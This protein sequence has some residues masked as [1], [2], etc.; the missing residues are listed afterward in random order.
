MTNT[1][2]L[3]AVKPNVRQAANDAGNMFGIA[4][5]LGVGARDGVSD[6]PKG[7]ALD[8]MVPGNL[9]KGNQVAQYFETNAAKYGVHY[10]IWKQHIINITERPNEGWRAMGDRGSITANHFD[11]VHVSFNNVAVGTQNAIKIPGIPGIPNPLGG[12][13]NGAE[14]LV[15]FF[16]FIGDPHNWLRVAEFQLGGLL[17]IIGLFMMTKGPETIAANAKQ[18]AKIATVVK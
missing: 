18:L 6:H 10:I 8:F 15:K 16:N 3:G 13:V 9:D 12:A 14:S 11:H 17:V 1:Y 7:L 5:I 2:V 4:T